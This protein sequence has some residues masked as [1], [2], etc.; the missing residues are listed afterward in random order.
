VHHFWCIFQIQNKPSIFP[1]SAAFADDVV[2]RSPLD[3][4]ILRLTK[5]AYLRAMPAVDISGIGRLSAAC[6]PLF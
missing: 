3:L 4:L 5:P 2:R 1:G 6:L